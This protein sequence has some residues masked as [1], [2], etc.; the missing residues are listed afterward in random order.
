M[1]KPGENGAVRTRVTADS[2]RVRDICHR[3]AAGLYQQAFLT[4]GDPASAEHVV[5]DVLA[6]ECALAPVAEADEDDTRYRLAE[7]VF[8]HC[9]QLAA[10]PA[11]R[12]CRPASPPAGDIDP[13]GLL[14]ARE[15]GALGLVLVGGLGYVR[16]SGVLGICPRDMAA[17]LR[18]ALLRM[19]AAVEDG[20][21]ANGLGIRG[22]RIR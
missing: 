11:W 20:R 22:S 8:R 19:A 7:S 17:L 6:D 21:Q 16:A 13:D 2:A 15:R 4:I 5:R 1:L 10:D 3:Y 9:E 18:A 12:G 14:S